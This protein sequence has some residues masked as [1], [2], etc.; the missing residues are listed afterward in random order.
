MA[1]AL[2]CPKGEYTHMRHNGLCDSFEN[3]LNDI[4]H[5]VKIE[6]HL[7]PLQG[8]TF[9][10]KS[11]TTDDDDARLDIKANGLWESRFNK[12]VGLKAVARPTSTMNLLK[13]TNMNKE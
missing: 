11:T 12:N 13:R 10:F 7:Q 6:P 5:D 9:T 1:H 3:L 2:F 4:C 8:E